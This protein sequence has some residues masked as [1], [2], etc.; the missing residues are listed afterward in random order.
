MKIIKELLTSKKVIMTLVGIAATILLPRLG[1]NLT[2][3]Q[4]ERISY[5][6]MAY[7]GAQGMADFGK[8]AKRAVQPS[9]PEPAPAFDTRG[10][11]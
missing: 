9:N 1:I 6:I 10:A 5:A 11:L 7:V 8:E 4:I 3:D 2:E